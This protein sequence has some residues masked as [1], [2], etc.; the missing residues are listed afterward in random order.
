MFSVPIA[1]LDIA[2]MIH[3]SAKEMQPPGTTGERLA[4]RQGCR[5][6]DPILTPGFSCRSHRE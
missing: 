6:R 5:Q 1:R 4:I 3:R 2:A